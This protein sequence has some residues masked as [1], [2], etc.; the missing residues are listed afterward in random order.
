MASAQHTLHGTQN[1]KTNTHFIVAKAG[2]T[3][4][5]A[6]SIEVTTAISFRDCITNVIAGVIPRLCVA[7]HCCN[8]SIQKTK[9]G[10]QGRNSQP[11]L[12]NMLK[13]SL[14]LQNLILE[15]QKQSNKP[16]KQNTTNPKGS[17]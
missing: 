14:K 17:A 15:N 4:E 5:L 9:A 3:K 7:A 10:T 13:A 6:G 8:S 11:G 16:T 2:M 12:Y 1:D